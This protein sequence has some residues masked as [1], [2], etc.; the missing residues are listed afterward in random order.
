[1]RVSLTSKCRVQRHL[2][3]IALSLFTA[4][5][6]TAA[7]AGSAAAS[8][9]ALKVLI[10]EAQCNPNMPPTKLREQILAQPGVTSVDFFDGGEATPTDAQ[11]SAYDVVVSI[12]ECSWKEQTAVGNNL[13]D[14]QD[15]GGIVVDA[16]FDWQSI[17]EFDLA[18]RRVSGGYSPYQVGAE[19]HFG[20]ANLGTHDASN[21]LLAGVSN[22]SAYY[23]D[24]VSLT[25]GATE[26]AK[27][28]DGISAV[29]V[30]ENAVGINAYLGEENGEETPS[31]GDFAKI[32]VNAGHVLGGPHKLTVAK[33]GKGQGTISSSP[34]GIDCGA[35]CSA[36]YPNGTLVTLTATPSKATFAGWSG[37]SCSG[38]AQCTLRINA[39]NSVAA[40]FTACIVP[41]LKGEKLRTAVR[42]LKAADCGLGKIK[43]NRA[44]TAKVNKQSA[45]PGVSLPVDAKVN[46]TLK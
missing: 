20:A 15:Q 44:K 3:R 18:G 9:G 8:P 19:P 12:G 28:S 22:L 4:V 17:G 23:R 32:I 30:K 29:A 43:G 14:Y 10:L 33:S 2:E 5:A 39:D 11:L 31:S 42:A 34:P 40:T 1:M 38:T 27:W 7:F 25:P 36:Q 45:K 37:G 24:A 26:I 13:A 6:L 41:K 16:A 21:P 35:T 46:L